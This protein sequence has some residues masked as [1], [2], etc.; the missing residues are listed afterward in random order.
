MFYDRPLYTQEWGRG[1]SRQRIAS[2]DGGKEKKK[3][4]KRKK[5]TE[6]HDNIMTESEVIKSPNSVI[7]VRIIAPIDCF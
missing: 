1:A 3:A 7:L 4:K 6:Y 2:Q 5:G